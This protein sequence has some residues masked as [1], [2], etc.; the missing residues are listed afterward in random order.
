[1]LGRPFIIGA[2]GV[3]VVVIAILLNFLLTSEDPPKQAELPVVP[4]TE[5]AA[6]PAVTPPSAARPDVA[7]PSVPAATPDPRAPSFDV[8]RVNPKGDTV[9]AGRAEPNAKI[10]VMDGDRLIGEIQADQRGEWVLLPKEPLAPGSRQLSLEAEMPDG[11]RRNSDDVVVLVVPE[12]DKDIAGQPSAQPQTPLAM[13]VP[14]QGG[15]A[16]T[17]LQA[18]Q[19]PSNAPPAPA[20]QTPAPQAPAAT[21]DAPAAPQQPSREVVS[22]PS[23]G[24]QNLPV[25]LD[26]I[27]YDDKG[28]IIFSGRAEPGDRVRIY[29][30]DKL[31]GDAEADKAGRWRFQP[32]TSVAT[33]PHRLR[34]D[35]LERDGNV[36]ARVELPFLKSEPLKETLSGRVVVIQPGNNLWRIARST[37]GDGLAFTVIYGANKDQIRDPDLIYPGQVFT[38]PQVN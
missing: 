9:I 29:M 6:A 17:V 34:V 25:T 2:I 8:V 4:K 35:K 5:T 38:L 10:R 12:P 15:G 19:A 32:E 7:K 36:V 24:G 33:G 27:D 28:D 18:P 20:P 37:Y 1:M 13:I 14:R 23:T 21:T 16:S 26:V 11:S 31:L 3:I 22:V 30:D